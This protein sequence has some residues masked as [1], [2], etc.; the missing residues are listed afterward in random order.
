MIRLVTSARLRE[1]E[2]S[3]K[4]RAAE[5]A[6]FAEARNDA[7]KA[8]AAATGRAHAAEVLVVASL[9]AAQ[10]TRRLLG[11]GVLDA[12]RGRRVLVETHPDGSVTV[13]LEALP[14][15]PAEAPRG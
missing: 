7:E 2:A 5:S 12:A 1:L 4:A 8:L 3:A 15:K 10:R 11:K 13:M 9:L 14:A 6:L